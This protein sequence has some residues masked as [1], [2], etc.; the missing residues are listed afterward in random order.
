MSAL[1]AAQTAALRQL[2]ANERAGRQG[3]DGAIVCNTLDALLARDLVC[4]T[5]A[6]L[7]LTDEGRAIAEGLEA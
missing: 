1:T 6:G 3:L 7:R 4:M 2:H 5:P